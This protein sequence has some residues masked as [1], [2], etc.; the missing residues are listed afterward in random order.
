M[1]TDEILKAATARPWEQ[2]GDAN[3]EQYGHLYEI[4][5]TAMIV[6]NGLFT[7]VA[8]AAL[9]VLAVN[10]YERDQATIRAL[11]EALERLLQ[12]R[13]FSR[14]SQLE[15]V[16]TY[17]CPAWRV[18]KYHGLCNCGGEEINT[19]IAETWELAEAALALAKAGQP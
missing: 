16:H 5:P 1:T 7:A 6:W 13:T 10:A 11:M 14:T 19:R 2:C 18:G 8:D 3:F 4:G 9:T 17:E 15:A 12:E